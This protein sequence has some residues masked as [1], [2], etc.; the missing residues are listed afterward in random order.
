MGVKFIIALALVGLRHWAGVVILVVLIMSE[1]H[2]I[3]EHE[4]LFIV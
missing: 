3:D 1:G 4:R 2:S